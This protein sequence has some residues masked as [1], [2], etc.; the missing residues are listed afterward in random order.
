MNPS[1]S[2]PILKPTSTNDGTQPI[3]QFKDLKR[4]DVRYHCYRESL[5]R[6]RRRLLSAS[7]APAIAERDNS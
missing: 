3:A 1:F 5:R 4:D 7:L 6:P 2:I